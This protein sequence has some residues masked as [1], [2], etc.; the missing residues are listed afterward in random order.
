MY[1]CK[2]LSISIEMSKWL[3]EPCCSPF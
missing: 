3:V 1:S 2:V